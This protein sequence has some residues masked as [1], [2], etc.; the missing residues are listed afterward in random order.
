MRR[1]CKRCL[2]FLLRGDTQT[3]EAAWVFAEVGGVG[4][5]EGLA[6]GEL[7]RQIRLIGPIGQIIAGLHN[8]AQAGGGGGEGVLGDEEDDASAEAGAVDADA[9]S[10][11]VVDGVIADGSG[12]AVFVFGADG[13]VGIRPLVGVGG[14]CGVGGAPRGGAGGFAEDGEG[15]G[16]QK[17]KVI[18]G[19][20]SE[21]D[22]ASTGMVASAPNPALV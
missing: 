2:W 5:G 21:T 13:D 20:V 19:G 6:G 12:E 22:W 11:V 18:E 4:E 15:G 7:I 1:V 10:E 17:R 16:R 3:Q 14:G 9:I 8:K